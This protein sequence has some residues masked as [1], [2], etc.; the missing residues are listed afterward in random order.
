MYHVC[1]AVT[2]AYL[3]G[4]QKSQQCKTCVASLDTIHEE[5]LFL[6]AKFEKLQSDDIAAIKS[7]KV[8]AADLNEKAE[9][10][11]DAAKLVKNK[12]KSFLASQ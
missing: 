8:D 9:N 1:V 5:L 11:V 12:L 3:P 7:F 10:H 6:L 4:E 2:S